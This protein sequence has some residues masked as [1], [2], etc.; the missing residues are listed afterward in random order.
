MLADPSGAD[1]TCC[2]LMSGSC[3]AEC[4]LPDT[5]DTAVT[6]EPSLVEADAAAMLLG[7]M[8]PECQSMRFSSNV[9]QTTAAAASPLS[10]SSS[11]EA[12]M[13]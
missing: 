8:Q 13:L 6:I 9:M 7:K 5:S 2:G 3:T 4:E 12:S 10:T 1:G 11:T